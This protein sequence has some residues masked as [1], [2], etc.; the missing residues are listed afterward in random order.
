MWGIAGTGE[1]V[2][3]ASRSR[4]AIRRRGV[5]LHDGGMRPGG[6]T[7]E[8]SPHPT[9]GALTL[10]PMRREDV[11]AA[12]RVS[13]RAFD[14]EPDA[15]FLEHWERRIAHLLQTDAAGAFAAERDGRLVGVAQALRR[16]GL[17]CLSLLSVLP[18][19]QS[20]GAGRALLER[21]LGYGPPGEPGLIVSSND[22]RALRL[23]GLSGFSLL[24][25]F[26]AGGPVDRAALPRPHPRIREGGQADLAAL[27]SISREIRGAAH[28][29]ELELAL[30]AGARL[31][32]L[33]DDGFALVFP[34]HGVWVLAA[35]R[36]PAATALL[37]HALEL[38]G[39]TDRPPLRWVTGAQ[40]WAIDTALRA[41]LRLETYGALAVRGRPGP[42][43]PYI[44]SGPFA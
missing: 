7:R 41:G 2:R 35:R 27:A 14:V 28:T 34:G 21:A 10:R 39:E 15:S 32:R 11:A 38:T 40:G 23:Y 16:E 3:K 17:W 18:C 20:T 5:S 8:E 42:L 36:E 22:P 29:P 25:T 24:P 26:Q 1:L 6:A 4:R 33:D 13:A 31:L 30:A 12:T 37:W 19:A 9:G 44:P 43:H